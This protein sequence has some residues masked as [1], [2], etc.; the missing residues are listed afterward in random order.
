VEETPSL[1]EFCTQAAPGSN[2]KLTASFPRSRPIAPDTCNSLKCTM[3]Q[4]QMTTDALWY[5][6]NASPPLFHFLSLVLQATPCMWCVHILMGKIST[7]LFFL[8]TIIYNIYNFYTIIILSLYCFML[9]FGRGSI[10]YREALFPHFTAVSLV[11]AVHQFFS[12]WHSSKCNAG[13]CWMYALINEITPRVPLTFT[14][15]LHKSS[16]V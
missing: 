15:S 9:Y 5:G 8:K 13:S 12:L 14:P 6:P 7:C 1:V 2:D 11:I 4:G 3:C 16:K 10:N